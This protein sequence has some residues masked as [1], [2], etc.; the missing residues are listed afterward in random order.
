MGVCLL[1][2]VSLH[3]SALGNVDCEA[4]RWAPG[5]RGGDPDLK[6][7]G[8][9]PLSEAGGGAPDLKRWELG[10]EALRSCL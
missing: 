4:R 9:G 6:D 3:S 10:S 5:E 1:T 7:W 8:W 2:G